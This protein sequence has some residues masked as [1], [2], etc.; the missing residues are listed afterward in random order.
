MMVFRMAH[1]FTPDIFKI[2]KKLFLHLCLLITTYKEK[3][4]TYKEQHFKLLTFKVDIFPLDYFHPINAELDEENDIFNKYNC[5]KFFEAEKTICAIISF[6]ILAS[7]SI[8][9]IDITWD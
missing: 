6:K 4:M 2:R 1:F 5:R 9:F 8:R 3:D 7:D